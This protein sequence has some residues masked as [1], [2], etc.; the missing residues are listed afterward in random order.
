MGVH[1]GA[2]APAELAPGKAQLELAPRTLPDEASTEPY[3]R[4]AAFAQVTGGGEG[5]GD[6]GIGGAVVTSGIGCDLMS[7]VAQGRLRRGA[8]RRQ[9][10]L[11]G[12]PVASGPH[13]REAGLL[14]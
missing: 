9:R 8:R 3:V 1:D 14:P 5:G 11:R 7:A 13:G 6:L 4:M 12:A 10:A 2:G